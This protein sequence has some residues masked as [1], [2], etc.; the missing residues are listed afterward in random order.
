MPSVD[1]LRRDFIE[2]VGALAPIA[3]L[4]ALMDGDAPESSAA[5]SDAVVQL[6]ALGPCVVAIGAFDGVHRGHRALLGAAI[7]EAHARGM[8]AVAVTFDP[9]PDAVVAA[10]P[11]R[12]LTRAADR[13]TL[14]A[15]SGV[16]AVAVIP[17]TAALA[18]LDAPTFFTTVL[19][20]ALAVRSIHVGAN[21]RLGHGGAATTATMQAWCA[22]RQVRVTGHELVLDDG[23]PISATRI[24]HQVQ[25]GDL[26]AV[27]R[28]LGRRYLIRGRVHTGRGEGT[29]MGFPTANLVVDPALQVPAGGVYSGLALVEGTVWPAAINVGKPPTF[30]DRP[31]SA[32]LEANLIGFHGDIYG[33]AFSL[34]FAE[35]LRGLIKFDSVDDLIATVLGN[36]DTVRATFGEEGV[37][38]A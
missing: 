19:F 11:A 13:L 30:R 32:S 10:H 22:D 35:R 34:V 27:E 25:K 14:L 6:R 33:D 29:G 16:D 21:F 18:A 12:K 5:S 2:P 24:R 31:A 28:E 23:K 20:A 1:D 17:F 38:L 4:P 36:I 15:A 9:D 3:W 37:S 8:A 7:A 26:P